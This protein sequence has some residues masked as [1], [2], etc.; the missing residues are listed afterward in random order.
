MA[1]KMKYSVAG[2]SDGQELG[3]FKIASKQ[4]CV[5]P[6]GVSWVEE[7]EQVVLRELLLRVEQCFTRSGFR[8]LMQ[9]RQL[10]LA[11]PSRK[12]FSILSLSLHRL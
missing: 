6:V 8:I 7:Q 11:S 3:R 5:F 12:R 2:A 4:T 1:I 10:Q 9:R